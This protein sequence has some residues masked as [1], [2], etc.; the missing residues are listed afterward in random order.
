MNIKFQEKIEISE[1]IIAAR[2]FYMVSIFLV[3]LVSHFLLN[4]SIHKYSF[5]SLFVIFLIFVFLNYYFFSFLNK[6]KKENNDEILGYLSIAQIGVE[7]LF[8]V[9]MSKVIGENSLANVFF[10]LP[11]I[12]A[13]IIFGVK[14]ALETAL[15]SGVLV[16][17]LEVVNYLN[18]F[19]QNILSQ[20]II[21]REIIQEFQYLT[22]SLVDTINTSMIFIVVAL[23]SGYAVKFLNNREKSLIEK[24]EKLEKI[25]EYRENEWKQLQR[26]TRLLVQR[27]SDIVSANK[28]LDKK[29]KDLERSEKS[30]LSVFGDLKRERERTEEEKN[31]TEAIIS[32]FVDPII[33]INKDG[34]IELAN[35][36]ARQIL[37][38]SEDYRN[39][40][41]KEGGNFSIK[42]FSRV[43]KNEFA[44]KT[45][46]ELKSQDPT[47]EEVTV[48][49]FGQ[50]LTYKVITAE[51][52]DKKNSSLGIMKIFNNLT[53][54]KTI[55]KLKSD[56]ISIA[57]HQLRTPLA[58]IKWSIKMVLDGDTGK[59]N[60][61]QEDLLFKGYRSN[62]RIIE[63]V[64][65]MLNVS[66][67]EEGRFGYSFNEGDL[68]KEVEFVTDSLENRIQDKQIKLIINKPRKMP[69]ILMDNQKMVLVFQNLLENAVKYTPDNG[70]I[71]VN[72]ESGDKFIKIS[73]KD[74][75]VGIPEEDQKKMFSKFFR[76]SNVMR[77][78]T[79][80]SG[81]GLFIVKNIINKHGGDISFNS[82]EGMGTEFIFTLPIS[83]K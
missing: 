63:L 58:A 73:I 19:S 61:E 43:I 56:F 28:Q 16:N 5:F 10:F 59:L 49:Y 72:I 34:M 13:S 39:V 75:G 60:S 12:S 77:M 14:G 32:N 51:V 40:K 71:E 66:R 26:A 78:Q 54:E 65:D 82:K 29:I 7:I 74:N 53:R 42:D 37:C 9:F 55:D 15:I 46:K 47:E 25:S 64:N 48:K 35:P 23:V 57:A 33:V 67:I 30:M 1:W 36:A 68:L 80:G 8:F 52:V 44:V 79:E 22:I 62:E 31:K 11:I 18:Y 45:A 41:I 38:I 69:K 27:E 3:G 70:K 83:G 50:E 76:A 17:Y 20:K 2:W 24:T 21:E 6:I 4:V 81:L